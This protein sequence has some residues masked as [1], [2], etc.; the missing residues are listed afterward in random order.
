MASVDPQ[1]TVISPAGST[2]IPYHSAYFRLTAFRRR[3]APQVIAYW[4]MS[5]WIAAAV[6]VKTWGAPKLGKPWAGLIAS[7]SLARLVIARWTD[8]VKPSV[9]TAVPLAGY[10]DTGLKCCHHRSR[11]RCCLSLPGCSVSLGTQN[12]ERQ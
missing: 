12:P 7:Y 4:L 6:Y 10:Q 5:A 3:C 9:R 2:S 11:Y 1:V 8:S